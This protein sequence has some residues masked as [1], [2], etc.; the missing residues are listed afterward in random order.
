MKFMQIAIVIMIF[1]ASLEA[2]WICSSKFDKMDNVQVDS[3]STPNTDGYKTLKGSPILMVRTSGDQFDVFFGIGEFV[4]GIKEIE[5][6]FGNEDKEV[7]AVSVSTNNT[8]LFIDNTDLFVSK[9]LKNK[10]LLVRFTP[11]NGSPTTLEFD[12]SNFVSKNSVQL[13]TSI[14]NINKSKLDFMSK[15]NEMKSSGR[16]NGS[17]CESISGDWIW[18][19]TSNEWV[20]LK[21]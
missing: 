15:V 20:C 13:H 9:M 5:A 4:G 1:V 10:N 16:L 18:N 7:Y 19:G 8:T 21:R 14:Q 3:C 17:S 6:K 11:Y 12:L 2:K